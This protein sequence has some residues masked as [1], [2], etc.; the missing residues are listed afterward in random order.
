[1]LCQFLVNNVNMTKL[2]VVTTATGVAVRF[3]KKKCAAHVVQ[4]LSFPFIAKHV[5]FQSTMSHCETLMQTC[6][7]KGKNKSMLQFE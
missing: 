2:Y 4:C 7:H 5:I 3:D 6:R 1:M